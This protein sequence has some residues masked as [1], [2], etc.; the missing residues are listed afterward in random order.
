MNIKDKDI[1]SKNEDIDSQQVLLGILLKIKNNMQLET[2]VEA[3]VVLCEELDI[4]EEDF[5]QKCGT[6]VLDFIRRDAIENRK[7][8]LKP[9]N[10]HGQYVIDNLFS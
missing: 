2:L 8:I 6:I 9:E 3:A 5:K 10:K 4:D 7:V 1:T